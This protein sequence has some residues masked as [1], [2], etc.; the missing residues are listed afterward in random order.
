MGVRTGVRCCGE[1][2]AG[3]RGSAMVVFPSLWFSSVFFTAWTGSRLC[4]RD[5]MAGSLGA[6]R[7]LKRVSLRMRSRLERIGISR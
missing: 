3:G 6:R 2:M 5:Y 1:A 4:D 7:C